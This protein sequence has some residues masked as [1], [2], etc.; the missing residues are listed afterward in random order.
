MS[1]NTTQ[2]K[3]PEHHLTF[4]LAIAASKALQKHQVKCTIHPKVTYYKQDSN[5]C[6]KKSPIQEGADTT[7]RTD[8]FLDTDVPTPFAV[9]GSVDVR[10]IG[11]LEEV[12]LLA[13]GGYNSIWLVKLD[14]KL[15]ITQA[16]FSNG[17]SSPSKHYP[18]DKYILRHPCADSL[19][20]NQIS[21]EVA[22]RRFVTFKLPHIPVPQVYSYSATN[23][24]DTSYIF[25]EYINGSPLNAIWM[26]YN[27]SQKDNIARRLASIVV[28]L[29]EIRLS[30]IRGLDPEKFESAPTVEGCKFFKGRG[31]LHRNESYPIG[32]YSST[33]E[34]MLACYDKE[35]FYYSNADAEDIDE[36]LFDDISIEEFVEQLR[37]KRRS[38]EEKDIADEPF[39]L[40][41][42]D[43]HGQNI[44]MK[45]DQ[46][47]AILDWEFAGSYPLSEEALSDGGID[48][49]DADSEELEEEN[50]VWGGKIRE[51]IGE[52]VGMRGWESKDVELLLGEGNRELGVARGEMVP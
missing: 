8:R 18:I 42:S 33:K 19:L 44:L 43:L 4:I 15:E 35:I 17:S 12:T 14:T 23:D 37:E 46:I 49:V 11:D 39:V 41:H 16:T 52:L 26:T 48:V 6:P 1:T 28:D 24:P 9:G 29:A 36:S 31:K 51:Y 21:N 27:P 40:I 30:K 20:P 50:E 10:A 34:Y 2:P 7:L 13:R 45:G 32:P 3:S 25:E 5:G 22:F 47:A 38:L